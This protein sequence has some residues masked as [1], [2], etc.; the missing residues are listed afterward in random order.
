[1]TLAIVAAKSTVAR[2]GGGGGGWRTSEW[3]IE[4][5]EGL[6]GGG[7]GDGGSKPV[8]GHHQGWLGLP[9]TVPSCTFL[10]QV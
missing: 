9:W 1:M 4:Y 3:R 7:G 10:S 8:I 6:G 5:G 2:A